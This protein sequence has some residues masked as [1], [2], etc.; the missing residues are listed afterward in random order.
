MTFTAADKKRCSTAVGYS[1]IRYCPKFA[2][3]KPIILK[4]KLAFLSTPL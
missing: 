3:V 4:K 2:N 1:H